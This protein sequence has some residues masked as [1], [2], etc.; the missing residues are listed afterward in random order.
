[1]QLCPQ[2]SALLTRLSRPTLARRCNYT[3]PTDPASTVGWGVIDFDWSNWKGAGGSSVQLSVALQWKAELVTR[4]TLSPRALR[5]ASH[6]CSSF[7]QIRLNVIAVQLLQTPL[8]TYARALFSPAPSNARLCHVPPHP[9]MD[10]DGRMD[11]NTLQG[12]ARPTGGQRSLRWTVKSAWPPRS[13]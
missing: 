9:R 3:G 11:A 6:S 1:M 7:P 12:L 8:R 10:A 13:P 5:N 4:H 2:Q